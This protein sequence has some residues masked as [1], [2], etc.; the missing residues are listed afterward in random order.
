MKK[1]LLVPVAAAIALT[2]V[3]ASA[4]SINLRHEYKPAFGDQKSTYADRIVV[5]HRFG[6]GIGFEVEAKYKDEDDKSDHDHDLAGN[7]HQANISYRVKLNDAFTLTPQYKIEGSSNLNHQFNLTLGYKVTDTFSV[8]YRQ[9]YNQATVDDYYNQGTF[10]FGYSGIQD[11]SLSGSLDYRVRG[12]DDDKKV[13]KD[14]NK[15]INEVNFKAQY[16][17]LESGWK[18]FAELGV[19]PSKKDSS[20]ID[21]WRPRV[22]VGVVYGF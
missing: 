20:E 9:R 3:G 5:S 10:A 7:G 22:R 6:S 11:I 1:L 2:S 16:N 8:S 4:A 14:S 18:P 21:A 13:W 17:G 19:I 12:G 15:G